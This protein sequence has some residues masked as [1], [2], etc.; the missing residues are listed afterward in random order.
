MQRCLNSH[1]IHFDLCKDNTPSWFAVLYLLSDPKQYVKAALERSRKDF[2][3][4]DDRA[5]AQ[6]RALEKHHA[7]LKAQ[8]NSFAETIG[9]PDTGEQARAYLTGK[10]DEVLKQIAVVDEELSVLREDEKVRNSTR[11]QLEEWERVTPLL[12]RMAAQADYAEKRWLLRALGVRVY[13]WHKTHTPR[14]RVEFDFSGLGTG[15]DASKLHLDNSEIAAL[16]SSGENQLD[17]L[18]NHQ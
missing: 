13:V 15:V 6:L 16:H 18:A 5:S 3:V 1:P 2:S 10:L 12:H 17:C 9:K 11:S 14:Y 4:E 7:T 8:A